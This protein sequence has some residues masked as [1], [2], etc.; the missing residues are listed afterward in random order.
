MAELELNVNPRGAVR[1]SKQAETGLDKVKRSARATED[2]IKKTS[3]GMGIAFAGMAAAATAFA[4]KSISAY[5]KHDRALSEVST[6]LGGTAG[7]M[8]QL[9]AAAKRFASTF[10]GSATQQVNAFYQAISAGAGSVTEATDLLATANVLAQGGVT[11]ITTAVDILTSSVNAYESAGLTAADAADILFTGVKFGKTTVD[12]LA[13]ALGRVSPLANQLG[14]DFDELVGATAALTK[15]GVS[16]AEAVT[17]L[18]GIM[19]AVLK[20][21]KEAADAAERLGLEFNASAVEAKGFVGFL[22]DVAAKTGGS[23]EELAKLFGGMESLSGILSLAANDG[24]AFAEAMEAMGL[25][26]GAAQTAADKVAKSLSARL[27]VELAKISNASLA[28]GEALLT[29]IVPAMEAMSGA[30]TFLAENM[31]VVGAVLVTIGATQIP[32]M[33]GA[34]ATLA[35]SFSS[36]GLAAGI[37]A[38]ALKVFGAAVAIAGGPLTILAALLAGAASYFLIFKKN[39]GEADGATS[40]FNAQLTDNASKLLTAATA[41]KAYR[42]ELVALI[43]VQGAAA[44]ADAE[45]IG[46][47][48]DTQNAA[49]DA[50]NSLIGPSQAFVERNI[51]IVT[52]E[53]DKVLEEY[54][55]AVIISNAFVKQGQE[56]RRIAGSNGGAVT[57]ETPNLPSVDLPGSSGGGGAAVD[58]L[59]EKFAQLKRTLDPTI[60]N[61]EAYRE[62]VAILDAAFAGGELIKTQDEYNKLLKQTQDELLNTAAAISDAQGVFDTMQNSMEDAFMA[63]IDGT[64]SAEDAFKQMATNIIKELYR[65]LV[66]QQIVGSF[67]AKT[68]DGSGIVGFFGKII[69]GFDGG[70]YTGNGSRTGGLDGKGGMMA[71]VHPQETIIDHSKGQ[72]VGAGGGVTIVQNMNFAEGV[73]VAARAEIAAAMPRIVAASK[74][75]VIEAVKRGGAYGRAF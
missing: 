42:E 43:Q 23:S 6:L 14:V 20:P 41:T 61:L 74:A 52:A 72:S 1:G 12:E 33:I 17:G 64:L 19:G 16:T 55:A 22:G 59:E 47:I 65:V 71:M 66:V 70:G 37:A 5:T 34:L 75:G 25:S 60:A 68:G 28:L 11:D 51:A 32:I 30:V 67:D 18:R 46:A 58:T 36:V 13:S 31:D 48:L 29:V 44:S 73:N 24:A 3:R 53:R 57:I 15:G 9:D 69:G 4:A 56:A 39:S 40:G 8:D 54:K 38:T 26:A 49:L 35:Q 10:G 2:Q 27:G 21:T 63:M 62:A 50:A 45:R 7:E